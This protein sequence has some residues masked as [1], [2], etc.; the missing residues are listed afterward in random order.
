VGVV[1][2][3]GRRREGPL[4]VEQGLDAFG[5]GS[6]PSRGAKVWP[7]RAALVKRVCSMRRAMRPATRC[8]PV[9]QHT[10][11]AT[12]WATCGC[13]QDSSGIEVATRAGMRDAP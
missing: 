2:E 12:A 4:F 13:Q 11:A 9:S 5:H 10:N 3:G 1:D 6:R 8:G 7:H